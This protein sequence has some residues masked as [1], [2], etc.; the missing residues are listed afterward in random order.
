MMTK[1]CSCCLWRI[2][3]VVEAMIWSLVDTSVG[4]TMPRTKLQIIW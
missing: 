2:M 1:C 4:T 3:Q